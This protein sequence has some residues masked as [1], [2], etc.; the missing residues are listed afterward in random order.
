MDHTQNYEAARGCSLREAQIDELDALA[1]LHPHVVRRCAFVRIETVADFHDALLLFL[2]GYD[3]AYEPVAGSLGGFAQSM[4]VTVTRCV[5]ETPVKFKGPSKAKT[6]TVSVPDMSPETIAGTMAKLL[7]HKNRLT[8]V[9]IDLTELPPGDQTAAIAHALC[10]AANMLDWRAAR[11]LSV[12]DIADLFEWFAG[13]SASL[14]EGQI[15]YGCREWGPFVRRSVADNLPQKANPVSNPN[16]RRSVVHFVPML[17]VDLEKLAAWTGAPIGI[18]DGKALDGFA[19][20]APASNIRLHNRTAVTVL[21]GSL[22][23]AGADLD[24]AWTATKLISRAAYRNTAAS[25]PEGLSAAWTEQKNLHR[26]TAIRLLDVHPSLDL[27]NLKDH[28][29]SGAYQMADTLKLTRCDR[30]QI[31]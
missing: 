27:Q 13:L 21:A 3:V 29:D 16:T 5:S 8:D 31:V 26:L 9:L 18:I 23:D 15:I 10:G 4:T 11:T 2:N 25:L 14:M 12:C 20:T 17:D 19:G 28:A 30:V 6:W 1:K 24:A 22:K 7:S